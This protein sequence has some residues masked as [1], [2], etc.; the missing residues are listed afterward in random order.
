MEKESSKTKTE[1]TCSKC[2]KCFKN[3][4]YKCFGVETN[5]NDQENS[6]ESTPLNQKQNPKNENEIIILLIGETGAGKTALVNLIANCLEN[7]T[8]DKGFKIAGKMH[9]NDKL[10]YFKKEIF[11]D[12]VHTGNETMTKDVEKISFQYKNYN[13]ML[14]DSPGI[15]CN[16]EGNADMEAAKIYD[17]LL[18]KEINAIIY[19]QKANERYLQKSVTATLNMI[20]RKIEK[21]NIKVILLNTFYPG[22]VNFK[23]DDLVFKCDKVFKIDNQILTMIEGKNFEKIMTKWEKCKRKAFKIID[24]II[25]K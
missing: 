14:I 21:L 3:L 10:N 24:Y 25:S 20:K 9:P 12:I 23:S 1:S 13:I 16:M 18:T 11:E 17:K 5:S 2:L 19:V 4:C 8:L 15:C 22:S 6:I 7:Q